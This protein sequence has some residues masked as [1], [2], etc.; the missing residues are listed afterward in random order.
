MSERLGE[1]IDD[2]PDL[3]LGVLKAR[4]WTVRS[5]QPCTWSLSLCKQTHKT[6]VMLIIEAEFIM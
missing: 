1:G 6:H 3:M 5:V 4:I 2:R